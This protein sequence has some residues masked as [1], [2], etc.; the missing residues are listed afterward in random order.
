MEVEDRRGID[1]YVHVRSAGPWQRRLEGVARF[2]LSGEQIVALR[3][4]STSSLG[5][6]EERFGRPVVLERRAGDPIP[7]VFIAGETLR[8][9]VARRR[10]GEGVVALGRVDVPALFGDEFELQ[11]RLRS[12][13]GFGRVEWKI[14]LDVEIGRLA[15]GGTALTEECTPSKRASNRRQRPGLDYRAAVP[16]SDAE[17]LSEWV[18]GGGTVG[19]E[20]QSR[21]IRL[22]GKGQR[23]RAAGTPIEV[24][25]GE[26]DAAVDQTPIAV[27]VDR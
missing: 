10:P 6:F 19:P 27:D 3:A 24:T 16:Q 11:A 9:L 22:D 13:D 20:P 1:E 18:D 2:E 5:E 17:R 21:R 12:G 8:R 4:V 25:E 15:G 7:A 23:L 26:R 14:P